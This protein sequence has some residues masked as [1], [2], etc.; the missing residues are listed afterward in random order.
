[1]N[2]RRVNPAVSKIF[3]LN[4]LIWSICSVNPFGTSLA[5]VPG[6]RAR[7]GRANPSGPGHGL[8]AYR[9]IS[10][11]YPPQRASLFRLAAGPMG[12]GFSPDGGG[13][14]GSGVAPGPPLKP[15][16]NKGS[17]AQASSWP[18]VMAG[19]A[20]PNYRQ[21]V[22]LFVRACGTGWRIINFPF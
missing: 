12:G 15:G 10:R 3:P 2:H 11:L 16:K 8:F 22:G 18:G 1:V 21:S 6:K 7:K 19:L 13:P 9:G 14:G 5:Y 17:L 4:F 20:P